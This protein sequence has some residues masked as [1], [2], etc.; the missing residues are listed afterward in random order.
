MVQ[1]RSGPVERVSEAVSQRIGEPRFTFERL[2]R[3]RGQSDIDPAVCRQGYR[4]QS[5][6]R[7]EGRPRKLVSLE[8][9]R[10]R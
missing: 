2:A 1:S 9:L 5:G 4:A 3:E 8:R 10:S 7:I 6:G